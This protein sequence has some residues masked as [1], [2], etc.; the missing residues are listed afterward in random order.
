M[1]EVYFC[2]YN[3]NSTIKRISINYFLTL[4][5]S[6]IFENICDEE[7]VDFNY[8]NLIFNE[9]KYIFKSL[10]NCYPSLTNKLL[11]IDVMKKYLKFI[12]VNSLNELGLK[13]RVKLYRMYIYLCIVGWYEK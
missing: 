13:N 8:H 11:W 2:K 6:L 5:N 7:N 3:L 4:E 10:K 1:K 9:T 12:A